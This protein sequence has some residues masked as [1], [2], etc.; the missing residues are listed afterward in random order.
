[1]VWTSTFPVPIY[2]TPLLDAMAFLRPFGGIPGKVY[3]QFGRGFGVDV[4]YFVKPLLPEPTAQRSPGICQ[5]IPRV[6]R[7]LLCFRAATATE[8]S[9]IEGEFVSQTGP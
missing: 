8:P 2:S 3:H 7:L 6:C 1:M 9:S 4:C 5:S